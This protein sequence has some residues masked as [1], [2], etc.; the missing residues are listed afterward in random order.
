MHKHQC[1]GLFVLPSRIIWPYSPVWNPK[2]VTAPAAS[3]PLKGWGAL[4]NCLA[5]IWAKVR[6]NTCC[7]SSALGSRGGMQFAHSAGCSQT[8]QQLSASAGM[9]KQLLATSTVQPA[10][11]LVNCTL[12]KHKV[13]A[14]TRMNP[15]LG[16]SAL[17]PLSQKQCNHSSSFSAKCFTSGDFLMLLCFLSEKFK[18]F[19]IQPAQEFRA[20][21]HQVYVKKY[22]N[23]VSENVRQPCSNKF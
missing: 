13:V 11:H 21:F 17:T 2:T 10:A 12:C 18:F 15:H 20:R 7:H 9:P 3:A 1:P 14:P 6:Q 4:S 5:I 8:P 19:K 23:T 22:F 16:V